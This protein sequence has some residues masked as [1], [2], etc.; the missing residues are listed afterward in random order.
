MWKFMEVCLFTKNIGK[1]I[2]SKYGQK[3]LTQTKKSVEGTFKTASKI[4]FQET[5]WKTGSK[6]IRLQVWS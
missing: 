3:Y 1:N 5:A 4:E 2:S 6:M